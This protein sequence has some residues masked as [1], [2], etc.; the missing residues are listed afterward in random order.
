MTVTYVLL[1]LVALVPVAYILTRVVAFAY[2][3]TRD[4]HNARAFM[5]YFSNGDKDDAKG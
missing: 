2:F 4:E 5:K 3:R 1:A